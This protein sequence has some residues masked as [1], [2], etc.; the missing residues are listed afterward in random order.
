M[1]KLAWLAGSFPEPA[2]SAWI[3]K[4]SGTSLLKDS[5]HWSSSLGRG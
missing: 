4:D 3:I 2:H 1:Q 5:A